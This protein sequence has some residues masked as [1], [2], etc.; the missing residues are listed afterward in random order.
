MISIRLHRI[1]IPRDLITNPLVLADENAHYLSNV[2]RVQKGAMVETFDGRGGIDRWSVLD[3]QPKKVVLEHSAH[4]RKSANR[5]VNLRLGLNPLKG[6]NEETAIRMAAS[7]EVMEII[8][9]FF[10]RSDIPL[11][12]DKMES[13]I[14][15]WK[16]LTR[17]EVA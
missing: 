4:E 12:D 15:R 14:N 10:F 9:V 3:K 17:S 6:A 1:Y 16:R 13:R 8:P 5:P 11:D 2:L 7:M